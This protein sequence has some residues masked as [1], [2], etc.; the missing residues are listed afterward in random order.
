MGKS[1]HST[2]MNAP[3]TAPSARTATDA[4]FD[5]CMLIAALKGVTVGAAAVPESA[6]A[7][8]VATAV[9]SGPAIVV[10]NPGVVVTAGVVGVLERKGGYPQN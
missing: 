3:A 6:V 7:V 1:Y 4:M 10:P 8:S 5:A 2:T 9:V